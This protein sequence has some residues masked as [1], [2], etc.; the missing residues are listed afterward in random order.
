MRSSLPIV[1][2][3]PACALLSSALAL[4]SAGDDSTKRAGSFSLPLRRSQSSASVPVTFHQPHG[5]W[6]TEF[7]I[8]GQPLT[9]E[10]DTGSAEL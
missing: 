10:I 6:Y 8:G 4:P 2:L 5:R 9:L 1:V 7:T 3:L